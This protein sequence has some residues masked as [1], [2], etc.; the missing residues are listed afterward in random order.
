MKGWFEHIT[1]INVIQTF[2]Y[3][4][5]IKVIKV[6]YSYTDFRDNKIKG[7]RK[8]FSQSPKVSKIPDQ[9][10]VTQS[11]TIIFANYPKSKNI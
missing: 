4:T 11:L 9:D 2:Y 10:K 6:D 7:Q 8:S 3:L 5:P 1:Q